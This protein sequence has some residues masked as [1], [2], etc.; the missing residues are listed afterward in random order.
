MVKRRRRKRVLTCGF[1]RSKH[2]KIIVG[3]EAVSSRVTLLFIQEI[4]R[5]M[6]GFKFPREIVAFLFAF[7]VIV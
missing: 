7:S 5:S 4:G 6:I 2:S 3:E 1:A